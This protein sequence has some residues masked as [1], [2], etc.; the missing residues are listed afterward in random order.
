MITFQTDTVREQEIFFFLGIS[1]FIISNI[2]TVFTTRRRKKMES[3]Y[4]FR[5]PPALS[6]FRNLSITAWK[7]TKLRHVVSINT[8]RNLLDRSLET[9]QNRFCSFCQLFETTLEIIWSVCSIMPNFTYLA[10]RV[11]SKSQSLGFLPVICTALS[12]KSLHDWTPR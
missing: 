4:S 12:C 10:Q 6:Y 8:E 7:E 3:L 11:L 1:S 9:C 5:L 2:Y